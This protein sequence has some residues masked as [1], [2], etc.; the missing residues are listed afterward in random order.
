MF[1]SILKIMEKLLTKI[2][3]YILYVTVFLFPVSFFY[4]SPNPFVVSK[5]A[6]LVTGLSLFFVVR[7]VRIILSGKLEFK[8]GSFDLSVLVLLVAYVLSAVLRTPNKM[9]ALLLPGT[10]SIFVLGALLY[11]AVNQIDNAEKKLLSLVL[12]V[13]GAVFSLFTILAFTGL[14]G[15]V[16]LL[17][18]FVKSRGFTPEGGY[19]PSAIF[20]GAILP[21][22]LGFVFSENKKEKLLALVSGV[23]VVSGLVVSIYNLLPG[24]AYSPRFLSY[25]ES[26]NVTVDSLKASPFMGIGAG[27]YLT[28]FNRF[29]PISY[30]ASDL[31]AVKFSTA[32][33]SVMTMVT[34][35]GLLAGLGVLLLVVVL[36]KLLSKMVAD[37][38]FSKS[39]FSGSSSVFSLTALALAFLFVPSTLT[40]VVLLFVLMALSS[41]T[42]EFTVSLTGQKADDDGKFSLA[43]RLPAFIVTLPII[44][45][46][47]Y[48]DINAARMF[49]A[50]N[51]FKNAIEA[52]ARNEASNTYDTMRSAVNLNPRVDRYRVSFS[53]V[54]LILANAVAAKKEIT[55]QDRANITTLVQQS[56]S[57]AKVAVAL[58]PLR[59]GNWESLAQIYRSIAPLAKGADDFAGQ[60]YRQAIVLD[61][62][63]PQTRIAL[64]GIYFAKGDFENAVRVFELAVSAKP[65]HANARYNLAVALE[66]NGKLDQAI[67]EMTTVLSLITNK[68]SKDYEVAKKA[69]EDLQSKKKADAGSGEELVAPSKAE[70]P[71]LK[72][73]LELPEDSKPPESPVSPTPTESEPEPSVTPTPAQ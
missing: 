55:D 56:I 42:H 44:G 36:Y 34:E 22:V 23:L 63:N 45:A 38:A 47:I 1:N 39:D 35:A 40:L 59:S 60:S 54:N 29:R 52:L 3:K 12:V 48:A 9:E 49:V 2:E 27:N 14:L 65:N 16:S 66:K 68:D 20:L 70:A 41:K 18:S 51:T 61:P 10:A 11:F 73:P 7:A 71:I 25:S 6:V 72:P 17:P 58:N 67:S 4:I 43:S 33:S 26:W 46:F 30:N 69:L 62:I 31:W 19:L 8:S 53:R 13:S 57:E 32:K 37:K 24:K 21:V 5:L 15:M 64:G 28:A 50:E